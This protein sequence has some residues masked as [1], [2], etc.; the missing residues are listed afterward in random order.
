L[1]E[2]RR[3]AWK[4]A[5]FD[6]ALAS[7]ALR[8][9]EGFVRTPNVKYIEYVNPPYA[10]EPGTRRGP[11]EVAMALQ[12]AHE[13]FASPRYVIHD[14]FDRGDAVVALLRFYAHGRGSESEAVHEQ[15]HIWTIRNGRIVRYGWG[16]DWDQALEAVGLQE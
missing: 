13:L 16:R 8:K 15:A 9:G 4:G 11:A 12:R 10:V 1:D 7:R 6:L 5:L 2:K 14:L 3:F